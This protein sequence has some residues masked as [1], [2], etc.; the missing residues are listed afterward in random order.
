MFETNK[1]LELFYKVFK[2]NQRLILDE[3]KNPY[4]L[5]LAFDS[6]MV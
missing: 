3:K 6:R 4:K 1:E 2:R 5:G